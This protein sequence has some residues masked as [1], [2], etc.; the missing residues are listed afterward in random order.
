MEFLIGDALDKGCDCLITCGG[1]QSNH[2]RATT[3]AGK[4]FGLDT[5]NF[6]IDKVDQVSLY[7]NKVY[8]KGEGTCHL[9]NGFPRGID[10]HPFNMKNYY[11][12]HEVFNRVIIDSPPLNKSDK[13]LLK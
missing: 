2:A 3:L 13:S 7:Y 11:S 9:K 5:H 6:L 10:L 12:H 1:L 4:Q 8:F